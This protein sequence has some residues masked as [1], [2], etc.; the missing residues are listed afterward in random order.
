[1]CADERVSSSLAASSHRCPARQVTTLD[2][3]KLQAFVLDV[4]NELNGIASGASS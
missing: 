4:P 1:M 2:I 3:G